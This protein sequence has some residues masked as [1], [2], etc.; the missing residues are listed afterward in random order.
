VRSYSVA[1]SSLAIHAPQKWTDNL[2]SQYEIPDV[3]R[4]RRGVSRGVSWPALLRIALIRELHE[5]L[6]CGVRSA[7]SLAAEL[8]ES[9]NSGS[10]AEASVSIVLDRAVLEQRLRRRLEEALESAPRPRR[11]RP[12]VKVKR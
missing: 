1:V 10:P 9:P 2:L 6:G 8:L 3:A 4:R 12:S 11:G 7:V 5:R